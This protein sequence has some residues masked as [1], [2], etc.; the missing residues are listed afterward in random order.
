MQSV[1]YIKPIPTHEKLFAMGK[2]GPNATFNL[3]FSWVGLALGW[4]VHR[5]HNNTYMFSTPT[6]S[7]ES[8]TPNYQLLYSRYIPT[9]LY[10]RP[11]ISLFGRI[12]TSIL[13]ISN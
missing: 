8:K 4:G 9:V 1:S 7:G 6:G 3:I 5:F 2:S 13:H 11:R 10:Y 12:C